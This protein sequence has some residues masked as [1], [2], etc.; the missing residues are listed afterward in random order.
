MRYDRDTGIAAGG[1]LAFAAVLV[2]SFGLVGCDVDLLKVDDPENLTPGSLDDPAQI[3]GRFNGALAEFQEGYSG[4]GSSN[5][6]YLLSTTGLLAD[7]FIS[8]GSFTTRT[9]VDRRDQFAPIQGNSSDD[10]F[11]DLH[12]AR[13]QSNEVAGDIAE[14]VAADDPRIAT[15]RAIEGYTHIAFGENFCAPQPFSSSEDAQVGEFGQPL[16]T[17]EIFQ[18]AVGIFDQGLAVDPGSNFN[19]VGK[20][21]AL[22]NNGQFQAAASAVSGVPTSFVEFIRHSENSAREQMPL[23]ALWDVGRFSIANNEGTDGETGIDDD[24]GNGLDF[25]SARDPRVPWAEEIGGGFLPEFTVYWV[26]RYPTRNSDLVV[27]DGIEARLIEAEAALNSGDI[28]GWLGILNDLR[29]NVESLMAARFEDPEANDR[30]G[31][32]NPTAGNPLPPLADPGSPEARVDLMFRERAFW[33]F[34]SNHR[35]GD[36]R[37]LIRQ[38][39]RSQAD[40]FPTGDYHKAGGYGSDVSL[41]VD[42][43]ESNNP[44]FDVSSCDVTQA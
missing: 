29:S 34:S 2:L 17:S 13:R 9:V 39:G 26:L 38:Y 32:D 22:L 31:V 7:E 18:E 19:A 37:R 1:F 40:I 25:V 15:L 41:P 6:D 5:F 8:T 30:V 44:N 4:F 10:F 27:A 28:P 43:D 14:L 11:L 36:L 23:F 20:G 35:L 42:F 24:T 21:R 3:P 12:Q 16:S 33:L